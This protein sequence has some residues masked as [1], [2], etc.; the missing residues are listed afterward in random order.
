MSAVDG[1]SE[2]PVEVIQVLFVLYPQFG[3]QEL[4]GPLEVLSTALQK[5]S[6]PSTAS[7]SSILL[8]SLY[9]APTIPLHCLPHH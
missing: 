9:A 1:P 3:L 2:G 7:L 4:A 8:P 6:D 5:I